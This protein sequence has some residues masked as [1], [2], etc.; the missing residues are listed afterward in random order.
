MKSLRM[1]FCGILAA[2][3]LAFYG[4]GG[5]GTE[6]DSA[7]GVAAAA[8][9]GTVTFQI[10][11]PEREGASKA[12]ID[13][14]AESVTIEYGHYDQFGYFVMDGDAFFNRADEFAEQTLTMPIGK[15]VIRAWA[16]SSTSVLEEIQTVGEI[17]AGPNTVILTF[18]N[19]TWRFVDAGG[20]PTP[21]TL[22]G[23]ETLGG[24]NLTNGHS[25]YDGENDYEFTWFDDLDFIF[26]YSSWV[27]H[28]MFFDGAAGTNQ[29]FFD[30][31]D[32]SLSQNRP[33]W[34]MAQP[35]DR[36]IVIGSQDPNDTGDTFSP[37][38]TSYLNSTVADGTTITG[39]IFE[40]TFESASFNPAD[41]DLVCPDFYAGGYPANVSRASA[42]DKSLGGIRKAGTTLGGPLTIQF[43]DCWEEYVDKDGDDD[44]TNDN[45]TDL[46]EDGVCDAASEMTNDFDTDGVCDTTGYEVVAEEITEVFSEVTVHPFIATG[47]QLVEMS[48]P[49]GSGT[50]IIQ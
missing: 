42:I 41:P 38:I 44:F 46:N 45:W 31:G 37:D 17:V 43:T 11:F 34:E 36:M 26:P 29:S 40:L 10:K 25:Y 48:P 5:S 12:L 14:N 2:A 19:G 8:D 32:Y 28:A 27:D 7:G 50:I 21:I 4:C 23:G 39:N 15:T 30:G 9:T 18:L 47:E 49:S 1:G 24:F 16:S 3:V 20:A 13:A 35:G 6:A 22:V 33:D